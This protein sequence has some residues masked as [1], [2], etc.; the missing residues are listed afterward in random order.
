[1]GYIGSKTLFDMRFSWRLAVV[2]ALCVVVCSAA[3]LWLYAFAVERSSRTLLADLI[4]LRPG[5][6]SGADVD[7]IVATHRRALQK[8]DC[9]AD[10]CK[11]TFE[12]TNRTLA[13]LHLEPPSRFAAG[14]TVRQGKVEEIWAGLFRTM[15]IYPSFGASAGVVN[16]FAQ[17]PERYADKGHY[18]FPTPVGKPYL[19]VVVDELASPIERQRAFAFSFK[20]LTKVGG[21]CDL[22]CDYLPL[23]WSDWKADLQRNGFPVSDFNRVYRDNQRCR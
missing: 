9:A 17:V 7:K 19:R 23:A 15:D 16:D 3:S 10:S 12:I 14:M 5:S 21:G 1:M 4:A 18:I 11:Y 22:P 13:L 20:C 8:K 2:I 6:S